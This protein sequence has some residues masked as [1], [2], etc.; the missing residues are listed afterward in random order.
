VATATDKGVV[1]TRLVGE[2]TFIWLAVGGH[3]EGGLAK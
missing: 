3:D 1:V 2:K